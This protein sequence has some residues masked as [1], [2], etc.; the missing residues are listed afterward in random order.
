MLSAALYGPELVF[1]AE[2]TTLLNLGDSGY[3]SF[4]AASALGG[5]L[6]VVVADRLA[7]SS[8]LAFL[9]V[10]F[11]FLQGAPYIAISLIDQYWVVLGLLVFSG[12][13]LVMV[14][15]IALTALQRTMPNG[16]MGRTMATITAGALLAATGTILGAGFAIDAFGIGPTLLFAGIVFPALSVL[17]LPLLLRGEA[18]N[19]ERIESIRGRA[20]FIETLGLFD[21][22]SRSGIESLALGAH[23]MSFQPG[24]TLINEGDV[25]DYLW[26]L[27]SGELGIS[28][29][30]DAMPLPPVSA[31][32]WVGE[33]GLLRN[34][35]RS[36]TVTVAAPSR[37]LRVAGEQFQ[38]A[39]ES[40]S[41]SPS[42]IGLAA[43]RSGRSRSTT[44]SQDAIVPPLET[45]R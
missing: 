2:L 20:D 43:E 13:G 11:L 19:A 34:Q 9:I 10:G 28:T 3:S 1:F 7:S 30:P 16:V 24:H 31:P 45:G 26:L 38:E 42:L 35:P 44:L 25:P 4:F 32:G 21:G 33:L 40:S 37:F 36:A 6:V 39:I 15:V 17:M 23:A 22:L 5:V 8:R 27:E 18:A 41:A 12:A 29:G 14:D